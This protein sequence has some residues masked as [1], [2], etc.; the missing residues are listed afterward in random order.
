MYT[1]LTMM[2]TTD[3]V[4]DADDDAPLIL[5]AQENP[6]AIG[7]LYERY[8]DRVY[9]YL[10]VRAG[11]PE[12]AEDLTQ[13]VFIQVLKALPRYRHAQAPF[14]AWLFRIARNAVIND[15]RRRRPTVE[16]ASLPDALH[17][18]TE[19]D[20]AAEAV[21]GEDDARMRALLNA[22]DPQTREILLLRFSGQ[23]KIAEIA[24]VVGKSEGATKQQLYRALKTVKE[25]YHDATR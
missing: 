9:A 25:H 15:R 11:S 1:P 14:A 18:S 19:G 6:S 22:L 7:P 24:H 2:A 23:L 13:Q 3:D 4:L 5:A 16:W 20:L 8:V 10:R 21:R 12:D 17:P